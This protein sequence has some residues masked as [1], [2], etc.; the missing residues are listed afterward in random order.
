[1]SDT[2]VAWEV[3]GI[4]GGNPYVGTIT[5]TGVYTAPARLPPPPLSPQVIVTAAS[6]AQPAVEASMLVNLVPAQKITVAVS[7]DPKACANPNSI[8][9]QSTLQFNALVTGASQNVTWQVQKLTGGNSTV[10]TITA[11]G[12]YTAPSQLPKPAT[13]VVSAIS[14]DDPSAVG[15]LPIT[16][17]L[18]SVTAVL[19]SPSSASVE[20]NLSADFTATV[21]GSQNTSVSWW[22]NGIEGGDLGTVGQITWGQPADCTTSALY[23]APAAIPVPN[24][25]PVT[26]VA[27]DGTSSP[28]IMVTITPA[29]VFELH[30]S[31]HGQVNLMIN[32]TQPYSATE[33]GDP[34]D[35]VTWSVAGKS[36]TGSACGTIT[37]A[38]SQPPQPYAATYTAPPNV[39]SPD[40][41]VTVTVSSVNHPGVSD[42]DVVAIT[43][44]T[45]SIAITP[46][47]QSVTA[48]QNQI[49]FQA[50]ISNYDQTTDIV[51]ELG[52]ISD[53]DGG[54]LQNCNDTDRDQDGPGCIQVQG[55]NQGCGEQ[56]AHGPGNLPLTYTSPK[57]L[58]TGSFQ[59]NQCSHQSDDG[60]G[61]VPLTVTL[62][63][64]GCPGNPPTCT[65]TACVQVKH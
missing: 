8:P 44:G 53:W 56:P 2:T 6:S 49:P 17:S 61:Y 52:C 33:D 29:P 34:N 63:A 60:T 31:P 18:V 24:P 32:Q 28:P 19:V 14:V 42:S 46:T 35:S 54:F 10:G 4:A 57:N 23:L 25:V 36:C 47:F 1:V 3:D 62:V 51:W 15:N 9:V 65:A 20:E 43:T 7:I 21:L 48:G 50:T 59:T 12:F 27:S 39:P 40:N 30:L 16:I 13:V 37:P 45:P 11:D 22:V 5:A 26:A 41:T 38:V 64:Q 55:G 58:F